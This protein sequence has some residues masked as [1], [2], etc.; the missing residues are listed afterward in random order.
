MSDFGRLEFETFKLDF[1][2]RENQL[3]KII[4]FSMKT[5]VSWIITARY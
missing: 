4:L 1:V 5:K 3:R 2:E